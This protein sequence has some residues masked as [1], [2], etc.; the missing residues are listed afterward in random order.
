MNISNYKIE[1]STI[2]N[3]QRHAVGI[4]I[5]MDNINKYKQENN[6]DNNNINILDCGCGTGNY[7]EILI[8]NGY[9]ITSIDYNDNML[10]VLK[11]KNLKNNIIKKVN[12]KEPL[13]FN[14]NKFDIVIINQVLHH[15]N[16]FNENFIYHKNLI[17]EISRIIKNNGLFTINTCSLENYI[18]GYWWTV[19][20][21]KETM[22][23]TKKYCPHNILSDILKTNDFEYDYLISK[24]TLIYNYF[25]KNTFLN[26]NIRETD[27][28][29]KYIDDEKYKEICDNIKNMT[30]TFFDDRLKLLQT[31]GQT[32]FYICRYNK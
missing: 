20:A 22:E 16:D 28:L 27:T 25:D 31:Y 7:T 3:K 30:D 11:Q 17:K 23:Y 6:I 5:I 15:L 10:E 19:F 1:T 32:T 2:Y 13:P 21:L 24:E 29:W 12:I 18:Y 14:D 26:E 9:N 8:Q 4:N